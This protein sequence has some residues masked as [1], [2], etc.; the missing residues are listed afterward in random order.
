[1]PPGKPALVSPANGA[2]VNSLPQLNATF[3]DSDATD[4]GTV[5]FQV[6]S[7][8]ACS[9]RLRAVRRRP[10]GSGAGASW[11]PP[12]PLADGTYYWRASAKDAAGN[13]GAWSAVHSFVLDTACA[14]RPDA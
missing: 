14:G 7:D 2:R 8:A 12:G 13:Q 11:T 1:M 10:V 4:S 3:V 9:R 6:C 5:T